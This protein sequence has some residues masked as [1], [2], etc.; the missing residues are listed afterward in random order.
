VQI[1][2]PMKTRPIHENLDTSFVNL[3][4]LLRYLQRRQF[5]GRVRVELSGY[6]ADIVLLEGNK[7]QVREHDRIAGR[8]GE[9]EE[10]LQ[11]LL[12]RA[13]EPGGTINVYQTIN[14][15]AKSAPPADQP[16]PVVAE[17]GQNSES[18]PKVLSNGSSNGHK[19]SKP[20]AVEEIPPPKPAPRLPDFPFD[21]TNEVEA[22][23]RRAQQLSPQDWQ[24]LLQLIGELLGTIDEDLAASRLNF[25]AAFA[26]VRAEIAVDYP[27][28][29]PA[30]DVFEYAGGKVTMRG[31]ASAGLLV[32]GINEA[33]RR[34]LGKL[35]ASPK[36]AQI[37]RALVQKILVLIRRRKPLYEKFFITPQLEKVLG[38]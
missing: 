17:A 1:T 38:V 23:A 26:K 6:E 18:L 35:G 33:L 5:V 25:S 12:I 29:N 19:I 32:A 7:I 34:I 37:Y 13:R 22:R 16:K 21:L 14:E 36:F 20:V 31:Q 27:F 10:A 11:R 8:T 24:T 3:S 28:L 4:A 15:T 2:I 9:G 30:S